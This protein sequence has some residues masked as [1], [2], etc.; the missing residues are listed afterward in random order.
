MTITI[1]T[2]LKKILIN[3]INKTNKVNY[4]I[5]NISYIRISSNM[6]SIWMIDDNRFDIKHNI[7]ESI[8]SK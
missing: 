1:S 8:N 6:I 7:L 3:S 4:T 2:T 5:K